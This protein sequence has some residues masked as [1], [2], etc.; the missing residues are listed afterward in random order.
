MKRG[1]LEVLLVCAEGIRHTNIIGTPVYYVITKC[2][3]KVHESKVSSVKDEEAWWNEKFMFEFLLIDWK[4]VTHL[5]FRIMD[6][7]LFTDGGFVDDTYEGEIKIRLKFI[8][9]KEVHM[10][11][12]ALVARVNE[13]RQSLCRSI[14]NHLKSSWSGFCFYCN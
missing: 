11:K 8:T 3:N 10:E 1:I 6:K 9:N 7:E 5:K 2:G 4:H 14:I 13:P 12:R